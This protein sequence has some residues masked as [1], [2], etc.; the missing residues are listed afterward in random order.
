MPHRQRAAELVDRLARTAHALQFADGLKPAQWVALRFLAR[1]NR[2][3]CTPGALADFLGTTKGTAS[4]TLIALEAKGYIYRSRS[5]ADRRSVQICLTPKG[6]EALSHDPLC[7]VQRAMGDLSGEEQSLL[8]DCLQRLLRHIQGELGQ[9]AF[10]P[11][12][13]CANFRPD[14]LDECGTAVCRCG[15]TGEAMLGEDL[16]KICVDFVP[17][18]ATG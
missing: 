18:K 12:G 17:A 16:A 6:Q 10:G 9:P 13:E 8:I 5:T 7:M 1:A 3:S 4:Q 11:C 2:Y 14:C 15:L